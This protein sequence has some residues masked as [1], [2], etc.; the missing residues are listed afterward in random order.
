[1]KDSCCQ[2]ADYTKKHKPFPGCAHDRADAEIVIKTD[3]SA[4]PTVP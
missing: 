4:A 1:M 3:D 2:A